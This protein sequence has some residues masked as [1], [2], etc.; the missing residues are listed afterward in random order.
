MPCS[1]GQKRGRKLT[2]KGGTVK[3]KTVK[4]QQTQLNKLLTINLMPCFAGQKRGQKPTA[5]GGTVKIK[6]SKI[7]INAIK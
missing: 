7:P 2:A 3:N 4:S 6:Q 1:A 5:K